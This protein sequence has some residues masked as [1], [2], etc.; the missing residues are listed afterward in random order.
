MLEQT[1]ERQGFSI[2]SMTRDRGIEK[3]F[4]RSTTL[5]DRHFRYHVVISVVTPTIVRGRAIKA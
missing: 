4:D 3:S 2:A 1:N 5:S